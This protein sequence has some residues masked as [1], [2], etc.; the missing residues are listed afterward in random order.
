MYAPRVCPV[1]RQDCLTF[2][3]AGYRLYT[4]ILTWPKL[5]SRTKCFTWYM[6]VVFYKA[7]GTNSFT[8]FF[9]IVGREIEFWQ[10]TRMT[11]GG[12]C[13]HQRPRPPGTAIELRKL[14]SETEAVFSLSSDEGGGVVCSRVAKKNNGPLRTASLPAGRDVVPNVPDLF[15]GAG[16]RAVWRG[17]GAPVERVSG[18]DCCGSGRGA[19]FY[20][21]SPLRARS[22]R[23]EGCMDKVH[24]SLNSTAVGSE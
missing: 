4:L 23:S 5:L 12:H 6:N 19:W 1:S 13:V 21:I 24:S 10:R 22:S 16:T 18:P 9:R 3:H 15:G 8:L 11:R 2:G 20:W 17:R 14:A 7:R